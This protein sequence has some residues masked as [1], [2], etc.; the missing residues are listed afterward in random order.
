MEFGDW[1]MELNAVPWL[2][3]ELGPAILNRISLRL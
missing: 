2:P 1:V 3:F